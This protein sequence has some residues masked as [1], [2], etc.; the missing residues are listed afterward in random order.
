MTS[1][2]GHDTAFISHIAPAAM[3]FVP[4]RNGTSHSPEEWA[5]PEALSAGAAVIGEAILRF[6]QGHQ[7]D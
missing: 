1:G 6:D 2:A 3:L 4:C 7:M 5:E